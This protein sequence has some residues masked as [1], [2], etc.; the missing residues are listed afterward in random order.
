MPSVFEEKITKVYN[1]LMNRINASISTH[2]SNNSSHSDIRNILNAKENVSEKS[3][4]ITTDT[5]ST[6][7]YPTVK[8][9]EDYAEPKKEVGTFTELQSLISNASNGDVIIL[10][11]DYKNSGNESEIGIGSKS[12]IIE[13]DGH[14]IDANNVSRIMSI[15]GRGNEIVINKVNFINGYIGEGYDGGGAICQ[16][17]FSSPSLNLNNCLFYNN[18]ILHGNGGA[19]QFSTSKITN[20]I[21]INNEAD[22]EYSYGGAIYCSSNSIIKNCVFKNNT[23]QLGNDVYC[24]SSGFVIY[25]CDTV[26]ANLY[27]TTN[28]PYLTDHQDISGKANISDLGNL[29]YEDDVDLTTHDVSELT[30]TQ[31]TAFTP[32]SHSHSI[33]DVTSLQT[34]LNGKINTSDIVNNLTTSTTGYVL[35]ASQGK[36]LNDNKSS[37]THTHG[38]IGNDGKVTTVK[39]IGSNTN[40]GADYF[41]IRDNNDSNSTK[42]A[43]VLDVLNKIVLDLIDES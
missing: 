10:D 33:S 4:S 16:G 6:T 9:V 23:A 38:N 14:T 39:T 41:L 7:K 8:A 21:F 36:W 13:G 35:D 2:N 37:S 42:S 30:D 34:S 31:N 43:N 28:K 25:D 18:Q 22:D 32:L 3:S 40:V 26:S 15:I 12:L 27:N 1:A 24:D 29:A 19:V 20:C 5:G 11:K 17:S